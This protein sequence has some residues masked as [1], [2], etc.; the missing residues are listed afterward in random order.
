MNLS[1]LTEY[2]YWGLCVS[3]MVYALIYLMYKKAI[4]SISD[5]LNIHIILLSLYIAGLAVTAI[6]ANVNY[7]YMLIA[8]FLTLYLLAG[9]V[10]HC[11]VKIKYKNLTLNIPLSLQYIVSSFVMLLLIVN[12]ILNYFIGFMPVFSGTQSRASMGN[13]SLPSLV[14][15]ASYFGQISF[16][17]VMLSKYRTIKNMNKISFVVFIIT[18]FLWGTKAALFYFPLYLLE[19]DFILNLKLKADLLPAHKTEIHQNIKKCRRLFVCSSIVAVILLPIYLVFLQVGVDITS[20]YSA[21]IQR[22]FSGFDNVMYFVFYDIDISEVEKINIFE[23]YLYPFV[24]KIFYT[25]EFQSAGEYIIYL[26]SN[27]YVYAKSG[28]NPNSNLIIEL[29]LALDNLWFVAI[30]VMVISYFSIKTRHVILSSG[31]IT[32][33]RLIIFTIFVLSPFSIL[34]DGANTII[35]FLELFII[36]ILINTIYNIIIISKRGYVSYKFY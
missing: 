11:C 10:V 7:T 16:L 12:L 32:F 9:S 24:K 33:K 35:M 2:I 17:F 5:P 25:P 15:L 22:F 3:L 30:F 13:V 28:M 31:I 4:V 21:I 26:I 18:T 34:F 8:T 14:L 29:L 6:Y 36:Y 20:S 1:F 27:D 19:Y 23:I